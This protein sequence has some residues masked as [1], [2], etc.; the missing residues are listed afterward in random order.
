MH[1]LIWGF[2]VPVSK[3]FLVIILINNIV[4]LYIIPRFSSMQKHFYQ[5]YTCSCVVLSE[6]TCRFICNRMQS[7]QH[8]V[9]FLW[10]YWVQTIYCISLFIKQ[11]EVIQQKPLLVPTNRRHL[12]KKFVLLIRVRNKHFSTLQGN[13][14][15]EVPD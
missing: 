3:C 4:H 10:R 12:H 7:K 1:A 11:E 9:H 14:K 6:F 13:S 15:L 2:Y 8:I 5:P